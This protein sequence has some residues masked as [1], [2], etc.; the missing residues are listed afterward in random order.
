[1]KKVSTFE[2][3]FYA[4]LQRSEKQQLYKKVCNANFVSKETTQFL[5]FL[6]ASPRKIVEESFNFRND[7]LRC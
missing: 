6:Y 3:I 2:T 7:F 5:A 4:V 1:M